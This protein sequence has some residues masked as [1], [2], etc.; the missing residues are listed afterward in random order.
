MAV[1]EAI[2]RVLIVVGVIGGFW[3]AVAWFHDWD[4]ERQQGK[5]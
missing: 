1:L 5:K 2:F 4:R 3:W